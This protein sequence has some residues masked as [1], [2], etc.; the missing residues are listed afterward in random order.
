[1]NRR[2]EPDVDQYLDCLDTSLGGFYKSLDIENR[3]FVKQLIWPY[4]REIQ[5]VLVSRYRNFESAF[6]ANSFL[7]EACEKIAKISSRSLLPYLTASEKELRDLAEQESRRCRLIELRNPD[8]KFPLTGGDPVNGNSEVLS[9]CSNF[10]NRYGIKPPEL[11]QSVT[12]TGALKRMQDKYWW[13]R[14]LRKIVNRT[15]EYINIDLNQV[16]SKKG[17]Y[18]SNLIVK[19][20]TAHK[21]KQQ[22][23]MESTLLVNDYQQ[24]YS[25]KDIYERNVS[26]PVNRRHE[27]MTRI[28]GFEKLAKECKHDAVFITLTCP[29]KF[30]NSYALSGQ[31]NPN[32]NGASPYEGQ[33]YLNLVWSRI[34]AELDRQQIRQYG[35][36]ISEPQHDGTPHWH[37]LLFIEPEHNESLKAVIR[38]Y[39][40]QQDGDEKGA[41]QYRVDIRDIDSN[42]GSATGYIAKYVSKNINGQGLE[43]DID[44]GNAINAAQRVE[45]WASCWGIR[46]FQQIGAGS[47][48]VW[49]EMRRLKA[50]LIKDDKLSQI[51]QAADSGNWAKFVT[52]MGGVFCK[53][54]EQ[55]VRPLYAESF[56]K[57]TG[58]IKQSW[59][60]G[61]ITKKLKGIIHNGKELVTRIYEW[62]LE[63][64]SGKA[65]TALSP[66]LGV[67]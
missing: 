9:L 65:G 53:R 35:F 42:K 38:R 61:L 49:R 11:S 43:S 1:M 4:P 12:L 62:R 14:K 26:N 48:T 64:S 55:P 2:F 29:S 7:R 50:F 24:V 46:Q 33:Q 60:D 41:E 36:R 37:L 59:F 23:W 25:L 56:N 28:A 17:K 66:L 34:R 57:E 45:A 13:L 54:K 10:V 6:D 3:I 67:L 8:T 16:N 22:A 15:L 63:H 21:E 47:V 5:K 40:L 52:L 51:H 44:G 31:R 39:A 18:C 20:R 32:W 19:R 30:H 27:L 58:Q